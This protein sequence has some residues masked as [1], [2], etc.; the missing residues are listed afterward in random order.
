MR[1]AFRLRKLFSTPGKAFYT[2]DYSLFFHGEIY[3]QFLYDFKCG[4]NAEKGVY[5][6]CKF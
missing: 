4:Y 5:A 3:F 1:V 6:L 2:S